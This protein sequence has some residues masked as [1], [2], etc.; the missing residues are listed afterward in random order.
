MSGPFTERPYIMGIINVTPDSFSDGGLFEDKNKAIEHGHLLIEQGADILD[1]GGESTRPGAK[2]ISAEQE[3]ERV[4][5]VIEGLKDTGCIL[6]IDTRR[7]KTM[8]RA[9]KAGAHMVNDVSALEYDQDSMS[10]VA[11]SKL[12]VC[13]MHMK[14]SPQ[15]MQ[16]N[17][18][19]EDVLEDVLSYLGTRIKACEAAGI[20][21][22]RIV[23][24][25]GIGFGKTLDHNLV[26][27]KNAARFKEL[28]AALLFGLSR[29]S[30]IEKICEGANAN[31]R[32]SG[33]LAAAL[34]VLEQGAD[35]LRVHD[36]AQT[37]QAIDVFKAITNA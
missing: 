5:P 2:E 11:Q 7:A 29:K 24:D 34:Y 6:S 15:K 23:I 1:I 26:L 18:A 13:L 36:V 16:Q 8:E 3:I 19:Y 10:V 17:P 20:D 27:I 22:Q 28:G 9:I 32:L 31:N 25:P 14:G 37:K 33:S 35:I 12:P 4:I 21:K 30:F